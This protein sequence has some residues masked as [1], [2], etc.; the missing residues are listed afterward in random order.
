M[1][2][3]PEVR[4]IYGVLLAS[5]QTGTGKS[6][7]GHILARLVGRQNVSHPTG[8][9]IIEGR[10][11]WVAE[12]RLAIIE[13]LY[14]GHKF[15]V[16]NKL[17]P[18]MTQPEVRVN[19]KNVKSYDDFN[20]VQILAT[21][22]HERAITLDN[23][24]RRWLVPRV[25]SQKNWLAEQWDEFYAWLS[26]D[27]I[28]IILRWAL[29]FEKTGSRYVN[30]GEMAP[31]TAAK[32]ELIIASLSDAQTL[33]LEIARRLSAVSEPA[34]VSVRAVWEQ[35]VGKVRGGGGKTNDS[36]HDIKKAMKMAVGAH[37]T[38]GR[39]KVG[40]SLDFVAHNAAAAKHLAEL[41]GLETK[42]GREWLRGLLREEPM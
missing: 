26:R 15:T 36:M 39:V 41:G 28:G 31:L 25:T 4:M 13:E 3:L 12:R 1:I 42:D 37:V 35:C 18:I 6:T 30:A 24:D 2:A 32:Q 17:K 34:A 38:D 8:E 22:N 29:D 10:N 5:S 14:E 23:E 20:C 40:A 21:S 7:L 27:G 33:A 19:E 11:T 9:T 16:A